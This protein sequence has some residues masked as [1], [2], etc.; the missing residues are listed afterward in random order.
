MKRL[1]VIKNINGTRIV[2]GYNIEYKTVNLTVQGQEVQSTWSSI[3]RKLVLNDDKVING[4]IS[5]GFKNA[6][7]V[8]ESLAYTPSDMTLKQIELKI[9]NLSVNVTKQINL[10]ENQ[11]L[12]GEL[13]VLLNNN[14]LVYVN[15]LN[16]ILTKT[17]VPLKYKIYNYISSL[18]EHNPI[19][20]SC[21][22]EGL[23]YPALCVYFGKENNTEAVRVIMSDSITN[24]VTIQSVSSAKASNISR[25]H[26]LLTVGYFSKLALN[27]NYLNEIM[28]ELLNLYK[29]K[30]NEI[31]NPTI[32]LY[33]KVTDLLIKNQ[34][35]M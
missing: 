13:L 18:D 12:L 20:I 29:C 24:E 25:L 17:L 35:L 5:L 27:G 28:L 14:N 23:V 7:D 34:N 11:V 26:C 31:I 1:H 8:I 2:V 3:G 4:L 30:H 6:K 32:Q 19:E 9:N 15:T 16:E 33:N 10:S 21:E 22:F